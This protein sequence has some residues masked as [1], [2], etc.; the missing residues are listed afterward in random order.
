MTE[1]AKGHV[2]MFLFAALVSGSFS[3][4]GMAAP[5]LD[6]GAFNAV[7]FV[8][9]SIAMGL[10]AYA[11]G[12]HVESQEIRV[13]S[14]YDNATRKSW[15]TRQG[16]EKSHLVQQPFQLSQSIFAASHERISSGGKNNA[17]E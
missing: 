12:G 5:Y 2:A 14:D 1:A 4:G 6:P 11:S 16:T 3:L 10:V 9:A 8:V 13:T 7:R 15:R 17:T